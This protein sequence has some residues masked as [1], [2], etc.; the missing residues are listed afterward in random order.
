MGVAS[1]DSQLAVAHGDAL[2]A[3]RIRKERVY[4]PFAAQMDVVGLEYRALPWSAWGREHEGT[5]RTLTVLCKR[6]ARRSGSADWRFVLRLLRADIA[7]ALA[8]RAS[9]M[10][11]QCAYGAAAHSRGR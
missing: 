3:M 6:A 9:A 5:T 10:W 4:T 11:R 7:A 2:E 8:R 1:P